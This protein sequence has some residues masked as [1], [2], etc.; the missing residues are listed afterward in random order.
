MVVWPK[1][2]ANLIMTSVR[3]TLHLLGFWGLTLAETN[4]LMCL[5]FLLPLKEFDHPSLREQCHLSH[6]WSA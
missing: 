6:V 4:H 3:R 2:H 5:F 1:S